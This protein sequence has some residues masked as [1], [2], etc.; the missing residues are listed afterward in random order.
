MQLIAGL[1]N[2]EQGW[3][4]RLFTQTP[5]LSGISALYYCGMC[6]TAG[7]AYLSNIHVFLKNLFHRIFFDFISLDEIIIAAF[8]IMNV[9]G[10]K[11]N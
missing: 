11:P 5:N 7:R 10:T 6:L 3:A 8:P 4:G 9:S 1:L 2:V